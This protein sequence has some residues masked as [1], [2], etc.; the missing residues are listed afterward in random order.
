MA[1][2]LLL[3][4]VM[5]CS[6][7]NCFSSSLYCRHFHLLVAFA[8][9][10]GR[11][12]LADPTPSPPSAGIVLWAP[13]FCIASSRVYLGKKRCYE[14]TE[15]DLSLLA[16]I[17]YRQVYATSRAITEAPLPVTTKSTAKATSLRMC[18]LQSIREA[19]NLQILLFHTLPV[20]T[21][22]CRML[23]V[24]LDMVTV[25]HSSS[26]LFHRAQTLQHLHLVSHT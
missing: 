18:N 20:F 9:C 22:I 6:L 26:I 3:G 16:L 7:R 15:V 17:G 10:W 24:N 11:A 4:E 5:H 19:S 14:I 2:S 12:D 1:A 13:L 8:D 21:S 23:S 25:I